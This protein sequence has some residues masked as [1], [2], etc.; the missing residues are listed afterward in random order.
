MRLHKV[1]VLTMSM[2]YAFTAHAAGDAAK[3]AAIATTVCAAC[4]GPDGNS[5]IPM[6]P[7]LAG[8]FPEYITKQLKNFKAGERKNPIMSGMV[9]TLTAEDTENI[10]AYFSAQAPKN[11]TANPNGAGIP[12]QFP[13]LSG[14]HA[15]Y[16]SAQLKTFR[17]GE[18]ANDA[19]KMMRM[20]SA[21]LSDQDIAAVADYI[22]GLH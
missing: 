21:R 3:G 2:M 15:D 8:Q 5:A 22:Q 16:I 12:V 10:G 14:Q 1:A 17:T 4:H 9:V 6:Y 13:R 19:A 20:V 18:R 7:K 11:G